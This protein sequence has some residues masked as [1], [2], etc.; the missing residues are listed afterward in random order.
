M[1]C[2]EGLGFHALRT[3]EDV[4]AGFRVHDRC[5]DVHGAARLAGNRFGHE[6]GKAVVAQCG[7]ADQALEEEHLVGQTD[8]VAMGEVQL[9]LPRAAFLQDAVDL[10]ALCFGEVVDVVDDLA[11]FVHRRH[12]IGLLARRAPA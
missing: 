2:Q 10:Q 5:V 6:R 7:L 1:K 11:V 4:L 12:R 8:W 9:D 3:G